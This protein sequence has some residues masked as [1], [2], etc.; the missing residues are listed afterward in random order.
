MDW[1]KK[2][3]ILYIGFVVLTLAFVIF[4]M[5]QRVDLVTDNYY[6]KELKYQEQIDKSKRTKDLKEKM[7][8]QLLDKAVKIK[9]PAP[10]DKNIQKDFILFYRPSDPSKDIKIQVAADS[11]GFQIIPV[12]KLSKGF[13]KIK[14]N[15][16]SKG[17]EFYDEGMLNIP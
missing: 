5:N 8:I 12:E 2:I 6:E 14:L 7:D 4:A 1:G 13:W 9:F 11:L 17:S 3:A 10:P 16:T 15:W